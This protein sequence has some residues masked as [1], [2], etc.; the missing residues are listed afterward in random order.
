MQAPENRMMDHGCP[1][2]GRSSDPVGDGASQECTGRSSFD[3]GGK[4]GAS[5]G[6]ACLEPHRLILEEGPA[7][8]R[9]AIDKLKSLHDGYR[10]VIEVVTC[11]NKAISALRVLLFQ[12]EPSGLYQPRC[13]AVKALAALEAYDVLV[14]Y[15]NAPREI[16]DPVE[17]AGEDSMRRPMRRNGRPSSSTMLCCRVHPSTSGCGWRMPAVKAPAPR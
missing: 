1:I 7:G 15:L 11:G 3:C 16:A 17:R 12:R 5:T 9:Q 13:L 6:T 4:D 2:Q 8:V 14:A 10:G